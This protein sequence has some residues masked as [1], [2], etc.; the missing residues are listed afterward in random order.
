M[1]TVQLSP[2]EHLIVPE[3]LGRTLGLHEGDRVEVRRRG[4]VLWFRRRDTTPPPGPLT[5]LCQIVSSSLLPN[6]VDVEE[7]M[8]KHGYEQLDE[9]LDL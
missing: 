8:D 5:E 2:G 6:S 4:Q 1:V 7:I 9:R 3:P